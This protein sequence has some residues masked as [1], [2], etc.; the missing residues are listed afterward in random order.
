VVVLK[1]HSYEVSA[2]KCVQRGEDIKQRRHEIRNS[3]GSLL[4]VKKEEAKVDSETMFSIVTNNN[5][6]YDMEAKT[7]EEAT[8]WADA[9]EMLLSSPTVQFALPTDT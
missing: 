8:L 6:Y 3:L 1:F 5:K 2:V 4:G 9:W 7:R